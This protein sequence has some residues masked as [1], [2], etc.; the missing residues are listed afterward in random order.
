MHIFRV[1]SKI[2]FGAFYKIGLIFKFIPFCIILEAISC[3]V[4]AVEAAVFLLSTLWVDI[5]AWTKFSPH[6]GPL[7]IK[8]FRKQKYSIEDQNNPK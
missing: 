7:S 2:T 6:S 3:R 5:I 8:K 1:I 4:A